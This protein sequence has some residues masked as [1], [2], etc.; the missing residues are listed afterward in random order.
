MLFESFG[1][2]KGMSPEDFDALR[3]ENGLRPYAEVKREVKYLW[4]R[5]LSLCS[6]LLATYFTAASFQQFSIDSQL[7]W[8]AGIPI[9]YWFPGFTLFFS[10]ASINLKIHQ[11]VM[12][13][14]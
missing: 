13:R 11:V 7:V 6:L 14:P 1:I 4:Y 12:Y 10:V 9:K 3:K 5:N 2:P 8:I